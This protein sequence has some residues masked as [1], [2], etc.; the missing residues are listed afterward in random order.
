MKEILLD[1]I[2]IVENPKQRVKEEAITLRDN[3]QE[4]LIKEEIEVTNCSK[5]RNAV[6]E[7]YRFETY[8]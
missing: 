8:E 6:L 5:E 2:F 3:T 7:E 1:K 4:T